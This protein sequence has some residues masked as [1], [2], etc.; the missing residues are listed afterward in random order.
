MSAD[1]ACPN[2]VP[3]IGSRGDGTEPTTHYWQTIL[4]PDD[5]RGA[6]RDV[7]TRCYPARLPDGRVL[8]LPLRRLPDGATAAAS[9]I[10][11]Q[12]SFA[13]L[14]VLS[15]FMTGL[16]RPI[17]PEVIVGVPTLG[18]TVAG[19][20]ARGL[21]HPNCVPLGYSRKFWYRSDLCEPVTSLT[22][23]GAGK[24]V[25]ID[26]NI[27]PRLAGRRVVVVDDAISTG[28]T[29]AAVLALLARVDCEVAGIVVAMRQGERWRRTLGD[30]AALVRG[31]F[32]A[33][34]FQRRPDGWAPGGAHSPM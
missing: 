1:G 12:A 29:A 7:Y 24:A 22:T 5:P 13:V 10:A 19:D 26:P 4:E 8:L 33:P 34:L 21:G 16:A 3:D 17:R 18:L 30:R 27:V 11:N 23:P 14:A 25:Y 9:L 15:Q 32:D 20:I 28:R 6:E 2:G 31:V